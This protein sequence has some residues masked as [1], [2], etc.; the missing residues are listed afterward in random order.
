MFGKH[1][2]HFELPKVKIAAIKLLHDFQGLHLKRRHFEQKCYNKHSLKR[3]KA[4]EEIFDPSRKLEKKKLL[5]LA[6]LLL[7]KLEISHFQ[8]LKD[9][10]STHLKLSMNQRTLFHTLSP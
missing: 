1:H 3:L 9:L 5:S 7:H 2:A 6:N 4:L 10:S 8:Q